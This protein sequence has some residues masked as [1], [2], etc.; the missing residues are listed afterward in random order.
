MSVFKS[1]KFKRGEFT[2]FISIEGDKKTKKGEYVY[3]D[4]VVGKN[5]FGEDIVEK[6]ILVHKFSSMQ[7]VRNYEKDEEPDW[8]DKES[9]M[10]FMSSKEG[11]AD[12]V[13]KD[14]ETKEVYGEFTF[15][16]DSMKFIGNI[17]GVAY[18]GSIADEKARSLQLFKISKDK[19]ESDDEDSD[20]FPF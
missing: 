4:V 15:H 2:A 12:W 19:I 1:T 3:E 10:F 16:P 7:V 6:R 13:C 8:K 11:E 18:E 20:Q 9:Y 14:K 17:K 5:E